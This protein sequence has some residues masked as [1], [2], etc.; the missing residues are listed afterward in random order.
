MPANPV[1]AQLNAFLRDETAA[2]ETYNHAIERV[3]D[4]TAKTQLIECQRS[5]A[6]RVEALRRRIQ[7]FGGIP[8]TGTGIWG[9]ISKLLEGGASLFGDKAAV[10][11]LQEGEER[12]LKNYQL[13][14]MKLDADSRSFAER[15][16]LAS[17]QL[18]SRSL[19]ALKT[20]MR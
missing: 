6:M 18:T 3:R 1:V 14:V 4:A 2:V 17:Q 11:A 5:H 7:R 9:A 19:E 20:T 8:S 16:L 13:N 15:E 12:V 10:M